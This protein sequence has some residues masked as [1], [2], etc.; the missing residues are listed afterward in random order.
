MFHSSITGG[1][2]GEIWGEKEVKDESQCNPPTAAFLPLSALLL[3]DGFYSPPC[4]AIG[5]E[6]EKSDIAEHPQLGSRGLFVS[7][8][9]PHP[10]LD[11]WGKG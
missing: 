7:H 1:M 11:H 5:R 9:P 3:S 6:P 2:R 10:H 4:V 8:L